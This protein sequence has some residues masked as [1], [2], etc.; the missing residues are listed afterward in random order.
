M[1]NGRVFVLVEIKNSSG[2]TPLMV[3]KRFAQLACIKLLG[4]SEE[5]LGGSSSSSNS[6][7]E[8]APFCGLAGDSSD[9]RGLTRDLAV[10]KASR[11][12]SF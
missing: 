10:K 3:A 12:K 2:E 11:S 7:D 5:D 9:T 8:D 6:D 4:G 1:F